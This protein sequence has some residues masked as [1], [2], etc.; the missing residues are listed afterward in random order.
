[1]N[2][3][4]KEFRLNVFLSE[5]VKF[6]LFGSFTLFFVILPWI[7]INKHIVDDVYVKLFFSIWS[8]TF[9]SLTYFLWALFFCPFRIEVEDNKIVIKRLFHHLLKPKVLR[10]VK[11]FE[12]K[13][14]IVDTPHFYKKHPAVYILRNNGESKVLA[15]QGTYSNISELYEFLDKSYSVIESQTSK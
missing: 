4:I 7:M 6:F 15:S 9:F 12:L 10:D 5:K 11:G 3:I 14:F 1:M 8:I 2:E 13:E